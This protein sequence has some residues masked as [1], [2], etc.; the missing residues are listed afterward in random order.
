MLDLSDKV[1]WPR[2]MGGLMMM[3]VSAISMVVMMMP[4]SLTGAWGNEG[5]GWGWANVS[6]DL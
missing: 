2:N 4:L 5:S 1:S 6:Y 3:V